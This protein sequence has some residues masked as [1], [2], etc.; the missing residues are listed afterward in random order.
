MIFPILHKIMLNARPQIRNS[1]QLRLDNGRV[2]APLPESRQLSLTNPDGGIFDRHVAAVAVNEFHVFVGIFG[3]DAEVDVGGEGRIGFQIEGF[4]VD[5]F[6]GVRRGLGIVRNV[7]I[8]NRQNL[9]HQ[10]HQEKAAEAA[11]APTAPGSAVVAL[12]PPGCRVVLG[13]V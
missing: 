10:Q 5:V 11:D 6:Q 2:L 8:Q 3:S 7:E 9:N 4:D 1:L 12:F 13:A